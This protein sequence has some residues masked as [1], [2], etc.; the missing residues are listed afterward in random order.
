ML[1]LFPIQCKLI[2][3]SVICIIYIMMKSQIA[4]EGKKNALK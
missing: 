4:L 3:G 2:I 1:L